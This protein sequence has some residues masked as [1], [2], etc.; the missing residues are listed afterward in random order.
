MKKLII[1][2]TLIVAATPVLAQTAKTFT[3]H[4][5]APPSPAHP[6]SEDDL[7]T[8]PI[9]ILRKAEVWALPRA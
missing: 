4:E 5:L 6:T 8:R 3:G 9:S 2:A 7:R 1:A